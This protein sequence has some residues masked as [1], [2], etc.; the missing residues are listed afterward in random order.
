MTVR[1]TD[2]EYEWIDKKPNNWT[3]R[4]GCPT[5]IRKT[6][7]IKLKYIYDFHNHKKMR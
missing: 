6:L 3:I 2:E 5:S 1:F 7:E 4:K